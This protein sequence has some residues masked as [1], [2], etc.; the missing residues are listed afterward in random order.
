M[1]GIRGL[2]TQHGKEPVCFFVCFFV[3]LF[4]CLF[5]NAILFLSF[6]QDKTGD[7]IS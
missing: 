6:M 3:S 4:L 2:I 7:K 5:L 1:L